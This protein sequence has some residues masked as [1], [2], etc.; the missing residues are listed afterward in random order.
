[1]Q[2]EVHTWSPAIAVC[3]FC[4]LLAGGLLRL[5]RVYG[6]KAL[7][8]DWA[9]GA[10]GGGAAAPSAAKKHAA[11]ADALAGAAN[12][13]RKVLG[14]PSGSKQWQGQQQ[15]EATR[16]RSGCGST[17]STG[18]GGTGSSKRHKLPAAFGQLQYNV[19]SLDDYQF[20]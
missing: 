12:F 11:A 8:N 4:L 6:K 1:M 19:Y 2:A 9:A 20:V 5:Q 10:A 16:A 14:S 18:S 3:A 13:R 15:G 17:S 7:G